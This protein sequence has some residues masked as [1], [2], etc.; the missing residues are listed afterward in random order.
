MSAPELTGEQSR[1]DRTT[2]V[3]ASTSVAALV[4][5][6]LSFALTLDDEREDRQVEQRLACLE[7]PGPNDC[8]L[9]GR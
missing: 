8:G 3:L 6:V 5:S 2:L 1:T 9:D 7:L 4:L